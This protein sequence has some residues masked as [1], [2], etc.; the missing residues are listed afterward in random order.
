MK[1]KTSPNDSTKYQRA[2]CHADYVKISVYV[3]HEK[4]YESSNIFL[5]DLCQY[6]LFTIG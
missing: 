1:I 6:M 2:H 4:L 3:C 5:Y